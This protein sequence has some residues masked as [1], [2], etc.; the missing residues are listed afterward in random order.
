MILLEIGWSLDLMLLL[1]HRRVIFLFVLFFCFE[2]DEDYNIYEYDSD[3]DLLGLTQE[4]SQTQR[5]VYGDKSEDEANGENYR[6]LLKSAAD[7]ANISG[8]QTCDF[9]HIIGIME[10][11]AEFSESDAEEEQLKIADLEP[12][13]IEKPK[14]TMPSST[15]SSTVSP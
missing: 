11:N 6:L 2:V 12:Q 13:P 10:S 4:L 3:N 15:A 8:N 14:N 7:L 5:E 9:D 1:L